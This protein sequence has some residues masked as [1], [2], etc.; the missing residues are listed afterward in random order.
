MIMR[1]MLITGIL[2][3]SPFLLSAQDN[4]QFS[5]S[6]NGDDVIEWIIPSNDGN[7][8]LAGNTNSMNPSR[9]GLIIKTDLG[10]NIIWSK[11]IGGPG[12]DEISRIISCSDGGYVAVGF[13]SSYGQG[14]RDAWIIRIDERGE[15]VWSSCFGIYSWDGARAV[16][17]LSNGQFM[18][19]GQTDNFTYGFMLLLDAQGNM[20]W[21]KEMT[22]DGR[23][24]FNSVIP[25]DDGGY[26]LT[27]ALNY[28]GFGIHDTFIME[29][30]PP[31][32]LVKGRVYGSG[33][34]DSF[35]FLIPWKNGFLAFGDTW[36]WNGRQLG[37]IA[38]INKNL[39]IGKSIVVGDLNVNQSLF[40]A[41]TV[42]GSIYSALQMNNQAA[43]LIK[44]DSTLRISNYWMFNPG[45]GAYSAAVINIG[46]DLVFSGFYNDLQDF[47]KNIYLARFDPDSNVD[48]NV[49]TPSG[50]VY[51]FSA[52]TGI[53]DYVETSSSAVYQKL[54]I[55]SSDVFLLKEDLCQEEIYPVADFSMPAESCVKDPVEI[56]NSSQN[57]GAYQWFFNG[58]EP[59][60]STLANPGIIRYDFP[61]NYSIK[62]LVRNGNFKDSVVK[63][64]LIY[65]DIEFSLGP[66]TTITPDVSLQFILIGGFDEYLWSTGDTSP[67]LNVSGYALNYGVN[68]IWLQITNGPCISSDTINIYKR[69]EQ[70]FDELVIYPNPA[71][72]GSLV[73]IK[74]EKAPLNIIFYNMLGQKIM[75][76]EPFDNS[77]Y[78]LGIEPGVYTVE[79]LFEPNRVLRRFIVL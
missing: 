45:N 13:T 19:V 17:Q 5:Y 37:W 72:E 15:V 26:F 12:W 56:I 4:F 68:P 54:N 34:D 76:A 32:N 10:G 55:T 69:P 23:F 65:P 24:W 28:Y 42:N 46:R 40:S 2:L 16:T 14:D 21:K 1:V 43:Y 29:A 63:N 71:W 60:F 77:F 7:L 47:S 49:Q 50:Y 31:G 22:R 18:V 36:S 48:C 6:A 52:Q 61:G 8:I 79:L 78:L 70:D 33:H 59:G 3:M 75:V 74:L 30:D 58:A 51:S 35:R 41:C 20:L 67:F 53:L 39:E 62:L 73:R 11:I 44:L 27:G 9:D 25:K 66:D 38:E 57:A 64:I